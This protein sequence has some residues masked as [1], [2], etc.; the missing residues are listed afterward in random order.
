[1]IKDNKIFLGPRE[2]IYLVK[3]DPW[4]KNWIKR[5]SWTILYCTMNSQLFDGFKNVLFSNSSG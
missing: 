3:R 5:D 4:M 2:V 1:M